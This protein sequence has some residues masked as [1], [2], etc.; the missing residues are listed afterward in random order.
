MKQ[1]TGIA[2]FPVFLLLLAIQGADS[3]NILFFF[4]VSTYSHRIVVWPLV[5]ALV[6]R[7]HNVT[8]HTI[9]HSKNPNPKVRE[10]FPKSMQERMRERSAAEPDV[11]G[12]FMSA[13]LQEG[14]IGTIRLSGGLPSVGLL[15]CQDFLDA[16]ETD[17]F[18]KTEQF[19]LVVID[20][21]F[22]ECGYGIAHRFG[23]KTI[24]F[25]TTHPF[26][27]TTEALGVVQDTSIFSE[28]H[29]SFQIPM[30]FLEKVFS[31]LFI[32]GIHYWKLW[33]Y[34]PKLDAMFQKGFNDPHM[35]PIEELERR[36]SL[37]LFNSHFSEEEARSLPPMF[38]PIGGIHCDWAHGK[39]NQ[40]PM[41][42]VCHRPVL[43]S[44]FSVDSFL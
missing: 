23:A 15:L 8:F 43:H 31:T 4:Q 21:L 41:S 35:P 9:Y 14:R 1:V 38:V 10:F 11:L 3:A 32:P 30:N 24:I 13:R 28:L 40:K 12:A 25:S 6:D 33:F 26:S 17:A 39:T 19:D 42:T 34:Y 20:P 44:T 16:P 7:G 5:E 36:T 29:V 22:N 2:V 37:V 18:I 27:W